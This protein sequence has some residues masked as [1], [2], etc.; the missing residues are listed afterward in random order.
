MFGEFIKRQFIKHVSFICQVS[1]PNKKLWRYAGCTIQGNLIPGPVED[2]AGRGL[3]ITELR[4]GKKAAGDGGET[5]G[6][7]RAR[8]KA[9]VLGA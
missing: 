7:R 4:R 1:I 8:A 6:R 9:E 5:V 3:G 2:G